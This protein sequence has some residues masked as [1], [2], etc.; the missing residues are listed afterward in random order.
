M[1]DG[2]GGWAPRLARLERMMIE[3]KGKGAMC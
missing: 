2:T 3:P 1:T